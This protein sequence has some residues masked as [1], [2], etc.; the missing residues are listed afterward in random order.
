MGWVEM[1][2]GDFD[3][4]DQLAGMPHSTGN[5]RWTG[6]SIG[7]WEGTALMVDTIEDPKFLTRPYN[8]VRTFVPANREIT[9]EI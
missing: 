8:S 5:D 2:S 4:V 9:A 6:D 3:G 1:G 7:K